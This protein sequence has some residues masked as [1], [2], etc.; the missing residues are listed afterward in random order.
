MP[1]VLLQAGDT[2]VFKDLYRFTRE[3][4]NGYKKYME[5][6][7]RGI[8]MVFLD[9]PTVSSDYIRQM[10]T[11]AEQQD[12]VTKTAMESIIKLL[13][14]VELDRGEKQCLIYPSLLKMELL[15][16]IRRVE[17]NQASLIRCLML[18]ERI[19]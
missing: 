10:M 16:A 5:W 8:N 4:E 7:D 2:V 19:F 9:N 12:I 13:I 17:E 11:T 1:L 3:A 15:Q 6:L 18:S 14:I